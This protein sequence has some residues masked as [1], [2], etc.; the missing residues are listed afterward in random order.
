[1]SDTH[2]VERQL[3]I[4]SILSESRKGYTIEE[5]S[6]RL[7]RLGIVVH[8][9]TIRRDIDVLSETFFIYEDLQ[10]DKVHYLSQEFA[11]K[12][13]TL[14]PSELVSIHF[15]SELLKSYS[16]LDIGTTA[17]GIIDKIIGSLPKVSKSFITSLQDKIAV[18][19]S[20]IICEKEVDKEFL[21]IIRD[22]IS[23][24]KRLMLS[25]YSFTSDEMTVRKFD[26]YTIEIHEG[27]YHLIGYCH[28]RSAVRNF[29]VARIKQIETLDE[30]FERPVNFYREFQKNRF[31]YLT[32]EDRILLKIRFRKDIAR[33]IKE[34]EA[35]NADL[36]RD[37]DDGS[38]LFEKRT[39]LSPDIIKWVLGFGAGAEVLAPAVL[40]EKILKEV[41]SILV[42]YSDQ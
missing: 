4:L 28:L 34:Y 30:E 1:M 29:R 3:H 32:G 2:Q 39:T 13:I 31:K 16:F 5:I 27:C 40:R 20:E 19:I 42:S 6:I 7:E 22:A 41:K 8:T 9:K 37:L 15:I 14:S 35:Q 33:F 23:L 12:N 21:R 18:S 24:N 36:I 26:P 17:A 10:N 25:Y 38:I 11:L